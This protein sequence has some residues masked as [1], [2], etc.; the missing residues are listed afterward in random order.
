VEETERCNGK[1]KNRINQ[2]AQADQTKAKQ[3]RNKKQKKRRN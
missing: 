2:T 1:E 3:K